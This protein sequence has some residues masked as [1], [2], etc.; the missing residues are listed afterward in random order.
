MDSKTINRSGGD[1]VKTR[2]HVFRFTFCLANTV[3]GK[4]IL[5][6]NNNKYICFFYLCHKKANQFNF[7]YYFKIIKILNYKSKNQM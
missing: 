7:K 2:K 6:L 5:D 4:V 3:M 1:R